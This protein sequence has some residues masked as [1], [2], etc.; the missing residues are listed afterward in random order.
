MAHPIVSKLSRLPEKSCLYA[1]VLAGLLLRFAAVLAY[2]HT[3]ESDEIA[4]L[5]MART[6]LAGLPMADAAGNHAMYN[7]GYPFFVLA[8][9][10]NIFGESLFAVRMANTALGGISIYLCYLVAR[11]A[12]AGKVG[13]LC[14]ALFWSLYLPTAIYTVYV[15]KENLMIPLM[16]V[17]IWSACRFV[18]HATTAVTVMCGVAFGLLALTGNAALALTVPALV[19]MLGLSTA[20]YR[21][22]G[23]AVLLIG[24]AAA[25]ASP[26][27][28][29]NEAV[30]GAPV[31]NTN[32]GF[33]LYLGN[34]PAATGMFM[35]IAETPR[36]DSW[37]DLR[38]LGEVQASKVL[39]QEALAWV[40]QHPG[41]AATNA[42]K[43]LGL[44]WM[45]PLHQ[46]R[47][48]V[49]T[50]ETVLRAAWA[51]QYVLLLLLALAGWFARATTDRKALLMWLA[52]GAYSAVHMIFYVIYRYREPI[53][54]LVCVL[55]AL[56]LD[57]LV[58]RV[59]ERGKPVSA[60]P[61]RPAR[62]F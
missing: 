5:T 15:A 12:G 27:I 24:V 41:I 22:A 56:A 17:V 31:L 16:L 46:G 51:A 2:A 32:G 53:M 47:D 60:A 38:K 13:R 8:P 48:Q 26:W 58:R 10:F 52:I 3:P 37:A 33:N 20:G 6:L 23:R 25:V 21:N 28:V 54:P 35:S 14:A 4:Y 61:V 42:M 34:N 18:S 55:A 50:V 39:Q 45:P 59:L 1:I 11:E 19:A 62:S 36:G 30:L 29:R 7:M 44:F 43:K 49:S 9:L 57:R 40:G